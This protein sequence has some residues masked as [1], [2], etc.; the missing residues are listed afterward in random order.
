MDV[1]IEGYLLGEYPEMI[2][3]SQRRYY[4]P[5]EMDFGRRIVAKF[6]FDPRRF[7]SDAA[8][9]R[10]PGEALYPRGRDWLE[11]LTAEIAAAPG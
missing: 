6:R 4:K 10:I 2:G 3:L 1:S 7:W 11:R 5:F 8:F 9:P